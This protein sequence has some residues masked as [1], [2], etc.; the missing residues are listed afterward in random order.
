MKKTGFLTAAV[1]LMLTAGNVTTANAQSQYPIADKIADKVI[2]HYQSASCQQLIAEKQQGASG[3][4][5]A[6]QQ[7][8]LQ[9][10]HN[11]PQAAQYFLNKVA[12][13]IVTKMFSCNMIP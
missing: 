10:L 9:A 13:P 12:G 8:A 11:N 1:F 2:A 4:K 7:K 5:S 3:Q 6:E